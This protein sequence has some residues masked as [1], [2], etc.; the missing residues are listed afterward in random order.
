MPENTGYMIAAYVVLGLLYGGYT[1]WLLNRGR[2]ARDSERQ[3]ET[4]R[5]S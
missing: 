4:A 3:R 2:T 1:I 5:D